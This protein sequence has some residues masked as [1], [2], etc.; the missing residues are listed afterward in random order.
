MPFKVVTGLGRKLIV[1]FKNKT[2]R[3][4]RIETLFRLF[5]DHWNQKEFVY[6]QIYD[7]EGHLLYNKKLRFFGDKLI[8]TS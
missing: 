1:T 2:D 4:L 3:F 6:V 7:D 8:E 5:G